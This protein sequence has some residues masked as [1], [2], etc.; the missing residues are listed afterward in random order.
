M[1]KYRI[2]VFVDY[3]NSAY[4]VELLTGISQ[5][6]EKLGMGVFCFEGGYLYESFNVFEP[7]ELLYDLVDSKNF[8]GLIIPIT[9]LGLL[10]EKV[11]ISAFLKKYEGIPILCI[12][13]A[14]D[15]YP[16]VVSN[17]VKGFDD[18]IEHLIKDHK[19]KKIGYITGPE[20]NV[21][22]E[23][24][25]I[26]FKN[27]LERNNIE[28]DEE[29]I[30]KGD[31]SP[32]TAYSISRQIFETLQR[33]DIDV[34]V[35]VND[36]TALV[37]QDYL[38]EK[39]IRV[40]GDIAITGF[41]DIKMASNS[42]P[43]L[44]TVRQQ[45]SKIGEIAVNRLHKMITGESVSGVVSLDTKVMLRESC[46]CNLWDMEARCEVQI[47][48]EIAGDHDKVKNFIINNDCFSGVD[49]ELF[50]IPFMEALEEAANTGNY[51]GL[52]NKI[53]ILLEKLAMH[54]ESYDE[55]IS[56][57]PSFFSMMHENYRK[58]IDQKLLNR[59]E[60]RSIHIADEK[61]RQLLGEEYQKSLLM[62]DSILRHTRSLMIIETRDDYLKECAK[63]LPKIGI[64][65]CMIA[66]DYDE[67]HNVK[68]NE[69]LCV[70]LIVEGECIVPA[71]EKQFVFNQKEIIPERYY[72]DWKNRTGTHIVYP[73]VHKSV[74]RGIFVI[75][76][77]FV[78]YDLCEQIYSIINYTYG[79][80][81]L[82]TEIQMQRDNLIVSEK[83]L[84]KARNYISDII[85]SMPSVLIGVD[86]ELRIVQWNKEAEIKTGITSD[87]ASGRKLE[88]VYP[89]ICDYISEIKR[90]I[91]NQKE[92]TRLKRVLEKKGSIYYED[93]KV[94]PL[95]A[96]EGGGAVIRIDDVTEQVML[97][98]NI[99]QS[100][101]MMSIGGLAAGM[102][103]EINN[104]L[105]GIM[106]NSENMARRLSSLH[107]KANKKA[108]EE[109][110]I[111]IEQ[112][113]EY[114]EKRK[115]FRMLKFIKN[116]GNHAAEIVHNMLS[117]SRKNSPELEKQSI[118]QLMD[119]ILE[120][121]STEYNL[122]DK[123][124]FKNI[125]I[126]KK[127]HS[128]IPLVAMERS[129]IQQV[130]YNILKNGAEA[131]YDYRNKL[132]AEGEKVR[133]LKFEIEISRFEA[134]SDIP[135]G[136][137]I[138]IKDNGPGMDRD[139]A[140]RIFEPFFT[141]KDVGKGTGLGLSIAYFI[142]TKQHNGRMWIESEPG[143]GTDFIIVLP[144]N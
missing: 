13:D 2:G 80:F 111:S 53:E 71:A 33:K 47:P 102:A 51:S 135:S 19:Y 48:D 29:L 140:K 131:M 129:R 67:S 46:G 99:I 101:K 75:T 14:V 24:R 69:C 21:D 4:Q 44:T 16:T 81:S 26:T 114:M 17:N 59:I 49:P 122:E 70:F 132:L 37:V 3:T 113:R 107:L 121:A 55:H 141:T 126:V 61:K 143:K 106:Q 31:F 124:D 1:K 5:S 104:P 36:N 18:L 134:E 90:S 64:Q 8:D 137:K 40:P 30:F 108:A 41:D 9:S 130:I 50:F 25:W 100:E 42:R 72:P 89:D 92:F 57:L 98:E 78:E 94:Y 38:S 139:S 82:L 88:E 103:H 93:L 76:N 142:I 96:D 12:G 23:E 35:S 66:L 127:Y 45:I 65:N 83:R 28:I 79:S 27:V 87:N 109:V 144:E 97:E 105:A 20:D 7:M 68:E 10:I 117:F 39:G 120:L 119:E 60:I 84:N 125:E 133:H 116:S 85:N 32:S 112:I 123:Y 86:I 52:P 6:A 138:C 58:R 63:L 91:K 62:Q 34:I 43:T 15:D 54:I 74:R 128:G 56:L 22:S 118:T 11:D 115:I 95:K 136:V 77:S 110:G 73:I